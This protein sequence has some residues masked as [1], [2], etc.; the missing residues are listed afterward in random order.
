MIIQ[1][2]DAVM[3][4]KIPNESTLNCNKSPGAMEIT[5]YSRTLPS[6]TDGIIEATIINL[7]TEASIVHNSL[8][9]LDLSPVRRMRQAAIRETM[10]ANTGLIEL[11]TSIFS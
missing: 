1:R 2:N 3:A 11:I 5:V 8:R 9:F 6:S 4:K 10:I 7:D